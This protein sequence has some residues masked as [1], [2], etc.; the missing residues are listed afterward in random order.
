MTSTYL[1]TLKAD[2][3]VRHVAQVPLSALRSHGLLAVL[4]FRTASALFPKG[5]AGHVAAVMLT[6][7]NYSLTRADIQPIARIGPG[8]QLP[9]PFGVV[10][11]GYV[12]IGANVRIGSGVV[13][14][15][16]HG[17]DPNPPPLQIG[18]DVQ[19]HDHACVIGSFRVGRSAVIGAHAVVL[20]D[21]APASVV[22]GIPARVLQP[23]VQA[24][25]C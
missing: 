22:E 15:R 4:L 13:L 7:L 24:P 6:R 17:E 19:I 9:R 12:T 14:G 23:D 20:D 10:I 16:R 11:G 8:L 25:E 1:A 2:L 18:D 3:R 21:V 5:R